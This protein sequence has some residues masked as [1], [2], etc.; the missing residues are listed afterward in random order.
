MTDADG[1]ALPGDPRFFPRLGPFTLAEI[2]RAI[3]ASV[4]EAGAD[5][6][7]RGIAPLQN[8]G[9][10]EISF[11][12]NRR[13]VPQLATTRAGAVILLPELAEKLPPGCIALKVAQPYLAWAQAGGLFHPLPPATPGRHPTAVVDPSASVDPSAE[14]GPYAI[15]GPRAEIGARSVIGPHVVIGPSVV[16]GA[17]CRIAA[18]VTISFAL[19][20]DR[21]TLHPG[22]RIGQDGFGFAPSPRGFVSV[23]QLG[24]VIIH[25]DVDIGANTTVDRGS[26]Q[27]TVIGAGTRIDNQV[28]IAH[29]VRLGRNC[30]IVAQVGISGSCVVEDGAV[31]AGQVGL[32]DHVHI[33]PGV[34]LG[35]ASGVFPGKHLEGPGQ[36]FMGVPAEPLKDYLK[37]MARVRR[38]K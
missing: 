34:I 7:F 29:N 4:P 16:I 21:V 23:T 26:A 37:T 27:D 33:G 9:P 14:I 19:I 18:Q 20:G 8:A 32:G 15:I 31:L 10:D 13:Y 30:V 5:R 3:D 1:G 38:L 6:R 12:D 25:P 2:A 28:Q 24:R 11:L 22:V 35:G 36:M 17:D